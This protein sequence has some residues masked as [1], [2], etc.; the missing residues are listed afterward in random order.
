M[1][2]K[3]PVIAII[4]ILLVCQTAIAGNTG[5]ISGRVLDFES[6]EALPGTNVIIHGTT[7]GA[8]TDT[9]GYYVILN[10]P[11]GTYV[12]KASMIGYTD[13]LAENVVVKMEQ[14]TTLDFKLKSQALEFNEI[15][16]VAE[17]PIV[18]R[19]VS[20]S[21][22]HIEAKNIEVLPVQT[23][24]EVLA[25]Q[26][27]IEQS[28]NGPVIRGGG[29][30]QSAFIVDGLSMND[31][32][33]N[34]PYTSLSL[35]SVQEIK[36]QT[37]GFNAEYGNVRSGVINVVTKEGSP[38]RYSGGITV[39]YRP[40]D[41]KHFGPSIY[42][43]NTYF[44]RPYTDPAV[45][46]TGTASGGWDDYTQRQYPNFEGWNAVSLATLQ[47][48][49]PSNDLTPAGAQQLWKWQHR[50]GGDITKPDYL[51]D[52]ALGGP[53]PFVSRFLGNSRFF[54]THYRLRD[55]FVF[56]LSRDSYDENTTQLK[57]TSDLGQNTKLVLSGVYGEIHSVTPFT[58]KTTPTGS[59]LRTTFD[60]ANLVNGSSGNAM[61]YMPG[62]FSPQ[63]IYRYVVGLKLTHMMSER[64]FY[65][66]SLQYNNNRYNA[67]QIGERDTTKK[68]EPVPGYF[69]DE[70]PWGYYGYS[71]TGIDG[72]ILGGWMNLGRDK[73]VNSTFRFRGDL[74]S[75][76]NH[77]NQVKLGI[78]VVYN[79]YNIRS[80]TSNPSMTTWNRSQEYQRFP[81]RVGTYVQ[82]KM[83]FEGFIANLG[84]RLDY[85]ST[86]GTVYQL[87]PYDDL[88]QEGNGNK[89]ET[90]APT[91]ASK[92]VFRIS[93]R[94]GV[95]HPITV[96]SKLYFNYG[97]FYQEAG[98][99]YRFRLQREANG[100]VTS[101]G[102]PNMV[103]E[104][105]VAY[106]LGYAHNLFNQFLLNIAA[107]YKDV[108][109][110]PGWIYYENINASVQYN[111]AANNNYQDIRGFEITLTKRTGTWLTG[112]INYTYDVRT[113]GFFG[114][115]RY[116]EDPN[117][118]RDYLRL[119]PKQERPHPQ[120]YA[121]LNL[122]FH[123]P[124]DMGS[125]PGSRTMLSEWNLNVLATW[126]AGSYTT[127]NPN[128]IPGIIDN[129]QWK[130]R[131]NFDLRLAKV[132]HV[133]NMNLQ[134]YLDITNVLNKK[135]LSSAGFANQFDYLDYMESLRF[136]WEDGSEKGNDRVGEYRDES[137]P[138]EPYD[139]SDPA[140]TEEDLQRIL[141]TKAY[142]DMP[143]LS[144]I[145][146]LNPREFRFGVRFEF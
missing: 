115:L 87:Q 89:I 135:F 66:V 117:K 114:L 141:E 78:D 54:L 90:E 39:Q 123:T 131:Y 32:R 24:N 5:K 60:V 44:T 40:P 26:A 119:N 31:E 49:D 128:S 91:E 21:E 38:S 79:D 10:V 95:A 45:A 33:S 25:L 16:V 127:Y 84:I 76:V 83:E 73:S 139:P 136:S 138:Y 36:V 3:T 105:T 99:T 6:G 48:D 18:T 113:S 59:Y 140:K 51:L 120:P 133:S 62:Y 88:L 64:S 17:R 29:A 143:N 82:D 70:A 137:V 118:Q 74:T 110:Q 126:R 93:P 20:A 98:S 55:V 97:H 86:N 102:D 129:V 94:L 80:F 65:E 23:V 22:M 142:I 68:Y 106:E 77:W 122:D 41:P 1:S 27:G 46:W 42:D 75:Q 132:F 50:R 28:G 11:P 37:G 7:L 30:N 124:R 96:N 67:F 47:D 71:V 15:V 35:N 85:S 13:V 146:F 100:L 111:K 53:I 108:T 134:V 130:A 9:D 107:Y 109:N 72:M 63:S 43:P 69:V 101:I 19:D 92:P 112:F 12:V 56:P 121:R 52:L 4:G 58:W 57:I 144:Y 14:T 8:A 104:K 103:Y 61:L 145:T 2:L 81:F 116:Y 125:T 34:I